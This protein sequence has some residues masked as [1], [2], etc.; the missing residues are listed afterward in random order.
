MVDAAISLAKNEQ[1][2]QTLR[3]NIAKLAITNADE[4]VANEILKNI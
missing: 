3:T 1:R 4:I 2:Q